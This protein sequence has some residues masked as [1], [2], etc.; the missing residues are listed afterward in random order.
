[1]LMTKRT[2]FGLVKRTDR[3][4]CLALALVLPVLV[5]ASLS[6]AQP[7][8]DTL[9][10]RTFGGEYGDAA[11][12][13]QQ[14]PDGGYIVAAHTYSFDQ[15]TYLIRLDAA[16]DTLWTRVH[17]E[18]GN[19]RFFKTSAIE[20]TADGG[21]VVA[22]EGRVGSASYPSIFKTDNLGNI[23][24]A[25]TVEINEDEWLAK[26][27]CQTSDGGYAL[28]GNESIGFSS[29]IVLIKTDSLGDTLWTR[30]YGGTQMNE[31]CGVFQTEDG[32]YV[33]AGTVYPTD[34]TTRFYLV[35]TDS[36][37]D[38]VWERTYGPEDGVWANA[39]AQVSD[40]GYAM[41]GSIFYGDDTSDIYVVRIAAS[42]DTLWTRTCRLRHMSS[43][44]GIEATD[45]G[46]FIVC[47]TTILISPDDTDVFLLKINSSGDTLW[48]RTYGVPDRENYSTAEAVRQTADG[49]YVIAGYAYCSWHT[50]ND[51]YIV[52]T[53]PEVSAAPNPHLMP[54]TIALYQ[55]YPNPFNAS[56]RIAFDLAKTGPAKLMVYDLLGREV[57]VLADG[58][59]TPGHYSV[60]FDGSD[61]PS[62][63]Y[64]YRIETGGLHEAKKMVL[65]K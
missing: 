2:T 17:E 12:D 62:G 22:G 18:Y 47:G 48:S 33:V 21:F 39:V 54:G 6:I 64:I 35:K 11:H 36:I 56:T 1:M 28:V 13:V 46:G 61:L 8:P 4:A 52:K 60:F 9:W 42:G 26:D 5:L 31:A 29:A 16:G 55:N 7:S 57:A 45:D 34:E 44:H 19:I 41:A 20:M 27:I 10:T 53:G 59:R 37:G 38:P 49:G 30:F 14:T 51:I 50:G 58:M 23:L 63:I 65:L 24:C 40:G 25:D 15:G 43:A 32:G 3:A